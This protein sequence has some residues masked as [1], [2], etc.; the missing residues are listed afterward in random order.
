MI[1]AF[2]RAWQAV[3]IFPILQAT[4]NR[5]DCFLFLLP[6]KRGISDF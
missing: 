4:L 6:M 5:Y 2:I 3:M 1:L